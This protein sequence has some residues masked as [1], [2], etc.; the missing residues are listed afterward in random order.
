MKIIVNK[1]YGGFGLSER[2]IIRY[3]ELAGIP[4]FKSQDSLTGATLFFTSPLKRPEDYFPLELIRRDDIYLVQAVEELGELA[5]VEYSSLRVVE[6]PDTIE[7][8]IEERDGME[9][10]IEGKLT[11]WG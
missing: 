7:W 8:E 11:R 2:A 10:V 1:C 5:D 4:L 9:W 6:V 3:S